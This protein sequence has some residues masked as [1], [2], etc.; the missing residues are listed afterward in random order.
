MD[1]KI[2]PREFRVY[3]VMG[4]EKM[5]VERGERKTLI[6]WNFSKVELLL[7]GVN[8]SNIFLRNIN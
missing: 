3:S 6:C 5:C 4:V 2:P 7:F 8:L 1:A